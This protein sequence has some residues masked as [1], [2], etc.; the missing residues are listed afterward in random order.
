MV[1]L[2]LGPEMMSSYTF[3]RVFGH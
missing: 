2:G 3:P 1:Q